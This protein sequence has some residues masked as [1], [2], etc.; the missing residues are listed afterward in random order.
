MID[1]ST[2][3]E[4]PWQDEPDE[5]SWTDEATGLDCLI[6]RHK[7]FGQLCGYVRVNPGHPLHGFM[8][9]EMPVEVQ[10]T[11]HGGITWTGVAP[12]GTTSWWIGFDCAHAFDY[13]PGH[14]ARMR[15]LRAQNPEWEA[16]HAELSERLEAMGPSLWEPVYKDIGYVR[17]C[18]TELAGA[19][20]V[21]Q[22]DESPGHR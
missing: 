10:E 14:E 7:L 20:R 4:G 5:L 6:L 19:L 9:D 21:L 22:N 2:W 3:G 8:G 17:A 1:K 12:N 18:V 15:E 13:M 11:A 16:S